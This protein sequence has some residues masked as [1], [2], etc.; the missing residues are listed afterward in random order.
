MTVEVLA[1]ADALA[2][3]VAA[4]MLERLVG[5]E[6]RAAICLSG[7]STPLHLYRRLAE[8]PFRAAFPWERLH[9]FWGDERFV[10]PDDARSNAR[11]A[12]EALLD[13][14]PVPR[15]NLHPIPSTSSPE[16]AALA[17]EQELRRFHG[18]EQLG[19]E[20]PLFDLTLLGLGEDGHTASLFPGTAAL[21][22]RTRWVVAV[23]GVMPETRITLTYPALESSRHVAFLAAGAAKRAIV[24]RVWQGADVPAARLRPVGTLHWFLD[25]TAAPG[26]A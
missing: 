14:I 9:W 23:R 12:R 13:R 6:G 16:D 5:I 24:E 10:P 21:A 3:R 19:P 25:R 22:E 1:D 15:A 20:R 8:P 11:M 18:A 2:Q 4:W 26:A 17:Y 7:G